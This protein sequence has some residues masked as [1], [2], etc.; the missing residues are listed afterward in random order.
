MN[1][2]EREKMLSSMGRF[3]LWKN[4]ISP[5]E[6]NAKRILILPVAV[7]YISSATLLFI[8]FR[9]CYG[10]IVI[11]ALFMCKTL[12]KYAMNW[13]VLI[14]YTYRWRSSIMGDVHCQ[15]IYSIA[16][17]VGVNLMKTHH[18]P[19]YWLT[20]WWLMYEC[21]KWWNYYYSQCW[22]GKVNYEQ[23]VAFKFDVF[24]HQKSFR[25]ENW[26]MVKFR[27]WNMATVQ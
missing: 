8:H 12:P 7:R 25:M 26:V 15:Y 18:L 24:K 21:P 17:F 13:L 10:R 4:S 16:Y 11:F 27:N 20:R 1:G 2:G 22:V 3:Q 23:S 14:Y 6:Q 5:I 19:A 9:M